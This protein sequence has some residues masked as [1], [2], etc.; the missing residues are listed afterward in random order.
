MYLFGVRLKYDFSSGCRISNCILSR[1]PA[2]LYSDRQ[3]RNTFDLKILY[4]QKKT[5]C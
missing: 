4:L 5:P 3:R 2:F 1:K